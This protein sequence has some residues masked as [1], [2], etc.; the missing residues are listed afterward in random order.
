MRRRILS[1]S[2][3]LLLSGSLA[4]CSATPPMPAWTCT[5]HAAPT[6]SRV[7]MPDQLDVLFVVDNAPTSADLQQR[8]AQS[9]P[10]LL[11]QLV[12]SRSDAVAG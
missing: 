12:A 3:V 4:A 7:S 8:F 11:E 5:P 2:P 1:I 9:I 6:L 10:R